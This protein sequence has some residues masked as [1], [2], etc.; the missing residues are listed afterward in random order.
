MT[1]E[2][3]AKIYSARGFADKMVITNSAINISVQNIFS[4]IYHIYKYLIQ[5][6][7]QIQYIKLHN[8]LLLFTK[9]STATAQ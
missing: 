7:F 2:L 4:I 9:L 3:L 8:I 6:L 1:I 5:Y